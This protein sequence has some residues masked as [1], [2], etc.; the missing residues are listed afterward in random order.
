MLQ[1][2]KAHHDDV[3]IHSIASSIDYYISLPNAM[4]TIFI[5]LNRHLN[6]LAQQRAYFQ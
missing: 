5:Y 3:A 6:S 2:S 1:R 4:E